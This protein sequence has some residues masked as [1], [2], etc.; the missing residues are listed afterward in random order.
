MKNWAGSLSFSPKKVLVPHSKDE[1]VSIVKEHAHSGENIRVTGSGHS[2]T[3]LIATEATSISL[4]HMQGILAVDTP[5]KQLTAKAGTKLFKLGEEA[6][7]HHLALENQGDINHQ[8]LAGGLSTGTHGTGVGLRSMANSQTAMELINGE[9]DLV[10]IDKQSTPELYQAVAVSMGSLGILTEI[11][12]QMLDAYKLKVE[13]FAEPMNVA[14]EQYRQRLV[15]NRHLEMFYFAQGDWS[16]VKMMNPTEEDTTPHGFGKRFNDIVLENWLYEAINILACK[17]GAYRPLDKL[18]RK[19]VDHKTQVAWSH[20]A[21]PTERSIKFMEMEYNLPI[22]KFEEVFSEI[23]TVIKKGGYQTLFPIEIR[24]VRGD[25]LWLS[26]AY[27]RDSVYFAIHTYIKE[28]F[29]SYFKDVEDVF[30]RHGGRPHWGKYHTLTAKDLETL[31]PR[32]N[33]FLKIRQEFDPKGVWLTP[34]MKSLF[35]K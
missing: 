18:M 29:R 30:K 21:F 8:S 25:K 4:D 33:D 22:D 17:S 34:Y 7:S 6:F 27:E 14:L 28:D 24:F 12:L 20:Q 10:Q 2:W 3:K 11:K 23:K 15:Q 32:W 31:Y 35:I 13:S 19:F 26:P 1:L 5:K 9:G 16:M